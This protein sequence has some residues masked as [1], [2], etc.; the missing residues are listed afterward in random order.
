MESRDR[1]VLA[2]LDRTGVPYEV[3]S[4]DPALSDTEA[5]C[6]EYGYPPGQTCNTVV[7]ASKRG[8]R[9]YAACVVLS[10]TRLDVNRRVR[11]LL[12]V[13]KVSFATTE[14]TVELTGM[15]P[16]GITPIALPEGVP[17]YVDERVMSEEWVIL[18]GG[19]RSIKIKIGPQVFHALGAQV[20]KELGVA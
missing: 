6:R 2:A 12:E 19:S 18:G 15:E 3:L 11:A 1:S 5:F 4:V 10:T 9:K 17:I 14:E 7:V 20:V 8:A 13:S 16:G